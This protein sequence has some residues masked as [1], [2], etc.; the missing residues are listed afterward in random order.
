MVV[1]AL[2]DAV[3][4]ISACVLVARER[5]VV[6]ILDLL[7]ATVLQDSYDDALVVIRGNLKES[8]EARDSTRRASAGRRPAPCQGHRQCLH[9]GR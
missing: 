9:V 3:S 2:R 5:H 4:I 7:L 8:V 6:A 1:V